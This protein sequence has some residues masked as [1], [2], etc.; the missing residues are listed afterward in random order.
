MN[1]VTREKLSADFKILIGDVDA[2][3]KATAKQTGEKIADLRQRL[4]EKI[5]DGRKRLSEQGPLRSRVE[6]A[7]ASA[8]AHLH[9]KP[10]VAL[11]IAAGIGLICGFLLRR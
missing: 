10:W 4:E 2:L 1:E 3:V 8:E 5:E 6:E 11:G 9:N 7:R